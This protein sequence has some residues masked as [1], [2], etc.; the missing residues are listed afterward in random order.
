MK[1]RWLIYQLVSLA[2][3]AA[4]LIFTWQRGKGW[5]GQPW[6]VPSW[7]A[8]APGLQYQWFISGNPKLT[9]RDRRRKLI[10]LL[11]GTILVQVMNVWLVFGGMIDWPWALPV[12]LCCGVV[13]AGGIIWF[14]FA[15]RPEGPPSPP[16]DEG[17]R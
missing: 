10:E 17:R 14:L 12:L 3:A 13:Q 6:L 7:L 2:I 9:Q 5:I 15:R 11:I 16:S 4:V 8:L 1:A